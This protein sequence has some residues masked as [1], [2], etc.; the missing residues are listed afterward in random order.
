MRIGPVSMRCALGRSGMVSLKREGDGGTPRAVMKCL[1]GYF[2]RRS[3]LPVVTRLP[4]AAIAPDLGWCDAPGNASYNRPVRLPFAASHERMHRSDRLYD[5]CIV[6][7]WNVSSRRRNAGSAIFMHVARP[8]Y[9]PTDGCIAVSARD[10]ARLLPR[11]ST[12][13]VIAA[14]RHVKRPS[15]R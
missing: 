7:D 15:S 13:A 12:S 2:R 10:M 9:A 5:L 6:L 11:L 1:Y 4:M 14:G 3:N 8:G